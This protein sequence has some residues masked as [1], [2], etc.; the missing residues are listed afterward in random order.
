MIVIGCDDAKNLNN[1]P[2]KLTICRLVLWDREM[3]KKFAGCSEFVE[4]CQREIRYWWH[5]MQSEKK[6]LKDKT[7]YTHCKIFCYWTRKILQLYD[8]F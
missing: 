3:L 1:T 4:P 7:K 2:D 5:D 8:N 6:S